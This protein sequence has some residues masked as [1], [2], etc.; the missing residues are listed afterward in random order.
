MV[1][2]VAGS[3]ITDYQDKISELEIRLAEA[4]ASPSQESQ[5]IESLETSMNILQEAML[6]VQRKI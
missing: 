6:N 1:G 2:F 4:S 5:R 3:V